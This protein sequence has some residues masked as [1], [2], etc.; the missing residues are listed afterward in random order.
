[1]RGTCGANARALV[2]PVL[3]EAALQAGFG[4]V[5]ALPLRLRPR[6]HVPGALNCCSVSRGPHARR[7]DVVVAQAFADLAAIGIIQHR[8]VLETPAGSTNSSPGPWTAG[9]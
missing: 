6:D 4:S 1:M 5:L 7:A 9:W 8:A 3:A 2:A